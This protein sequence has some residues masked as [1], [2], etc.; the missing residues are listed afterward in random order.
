M[1]EIKMKLTKRITIHRHVVIYVRIEYEVIRRYLTLKEE[2]EEKR[3]SGSNI[4]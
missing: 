4:L 1:T 3:S 2:S